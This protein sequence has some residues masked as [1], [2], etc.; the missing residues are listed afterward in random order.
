[1]NAD[2]LVDD[3]KKITKDSK[4]RRMTFAIKLG[5]TS[6]IFNLKK[7]F[8]ANQE[9]Q[10]VDDSSQASSDSISEDGQSPGRRRP[11]S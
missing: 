1:M 5:T 7:K 3:L 4:G 9:Q 11:G 8:S 6:P 10:V 2:I